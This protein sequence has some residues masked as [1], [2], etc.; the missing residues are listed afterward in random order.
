MDLDQLGATD[1]PL[2]VFE[3]LKIRVWSGGERERSVRVACAGRRC[4]FQTVLSK[5]LVESPPTT[6]PPRMINDG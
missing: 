4:S 6:P 1:S 5:H 2:Q 3:W